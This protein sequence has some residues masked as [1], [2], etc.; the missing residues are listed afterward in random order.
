MDHITFYI[1]RKLPK[2]NPRRLKSYTV[3]GTNIS[4]IN[5]KD[6]FCNPIIQDYSDTLSFPI[7]VEKS[8][9]SNVRDNEAEIARKLPPHWVLCFALRAVDKKV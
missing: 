6:L 4:G 8:Y 2:T 3:F 5:F 7:A 9:K 1:E